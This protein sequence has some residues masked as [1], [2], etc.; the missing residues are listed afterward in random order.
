MISQTHS[1]ACELLFVLTQWKA[2]GRFLLKG[3]E[4]NVLVWS[5]RGTPL[6]GT[7]LLASFLPEAGRVAEAGDVRWVCA[8]WAPSALTQMHGAVKA[9][10]YV[11]VKKMVIF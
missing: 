1:Y 9:A 10:C 4:R 8:L 5:S 7:V 6:M 2:G 3:M 11:A